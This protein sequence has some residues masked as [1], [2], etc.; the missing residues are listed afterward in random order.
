MNKFCLRFENLPSSQYFN[1]ENTILK[2]KLWIQL[3]EIIKEVIEEKKVTFLD[4]LK[5]KAVGFVGFDFFKKKE[6]EPIIESD[7]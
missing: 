5:N 3:N 7:D 1:G 2:Q 4:K 6:E